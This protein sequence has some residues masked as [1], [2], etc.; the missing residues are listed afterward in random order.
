MS[1]DLIK[2]YKSII[3]VFCM[4]LLLTE[5][6]AFSKKRSMFTIKKT[7]QKK[8]NWLV[9]IRLHKKRQLFTSYTANEC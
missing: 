8:K 2:H 9:L 4:Y 5:K 3:D 6:S 7:S 1:A